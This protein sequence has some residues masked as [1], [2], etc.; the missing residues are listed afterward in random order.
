MDNRYKKIE[1]NNSCY[2]F[3]VDDF[4]IIKIEDDSLDISRIIKEKL[5]NANKIKDF[6]EK[7]IEVRPKSMIGINIIS[8]CNLNCGYCYLTASKKPIQKLTKERFIDILK[9]FENEKDHHIVLYFIGGG[10]PTLNF[11]LL[12]MIPE[13]CFAGGFKDVSFELTTNGTTL[14]D[15]MME[16]IKKNKVT[17]Y[18][19]FDGSKRTNASRVYKDGRGIFEDVYNNLRKLELN[20][21]DYKCKALI[22]PC[23]KNMLDAFLFFEDNK[24]SFKFDF[25]TDSFDGRYMPKISEL[26]DFSS[27]LEGVL[28]VYKKKIIAN[29]KVYSE[30]II[31]DLKRLHY[32][33]TNKIACSASINGFIVDLDGKIYTCTMNSNSPMLS[34][35]SI[36]SII[37]YDK[38]IREGFFAKPVDC[39]RTCEDC[40]VK[41]LCSGGCFALNKLKNNDVAKPYEY[42]CIIEKL[43]W[44]SMIKMYIKLWYSTNISDNINFI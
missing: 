34:V 14:T 24:I 11:E 25:A 40:W 32:G 19:S 9:F 16:F 39:Y 27:Q 30:N 33:L 20:D 5:I 17:L 31:L 10:E 3:C 35:G 8:G 28:D 36:Y 23:N 6:D 2:Y 13:L 18:I 44:E 41:Y 42:M 37:N 4:E 22:Q 43:Y 12:K 7:Q 29:E 26:E 1:V 15:E 21:I 38:I